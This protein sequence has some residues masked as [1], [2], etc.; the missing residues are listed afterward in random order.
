MLSLLELCLKQRHKTFE[1]K[2]LSNAGLKLKK[3]TQ[4]WIL[5]SG[6]IR[7]IA[8]SLKWENELI[9]LIGREKG[10]TRSKNKEQN[11]L[12]WTHFLL[13]NIFSKGAQD[14]S[15]I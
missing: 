7:N 8:K 12:L 1:N 15:L 10:R 5:I 11:W 9:R 13:M 2:R 3:L 4:G 14:V 6:K